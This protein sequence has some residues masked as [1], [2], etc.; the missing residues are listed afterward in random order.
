MNRVATSCI[1]MRP[2]SIQI[3]TINIDDV[4][5]F[6]TVFYLIRQ[7]QKTVSDISCRGNKTK[8]WN[9][10]GVYTV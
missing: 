6:N 10:Q 5:L 8:R 2:I 7:S 4:I 9:Y 1:L 3:H